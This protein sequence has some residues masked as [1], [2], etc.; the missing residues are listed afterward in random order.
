MER[1]PQRW[2][3]L[4]LAA[5]GLILVSAA[6]IHSFVPGLELLRPGLLLALAGL[7]LLV[8]NY[9]G[10]RRIEHLKNPLGLLLGFLFVWAL[11]TAPFGLYVGNSIRFTLESFGRTILVAVV[12]ATAIRDLHDLER[13][14]K[15]YALG[16]IGFAILGQ[17]T[18]G[19]RDFGGGGYDPNDG[20]MFVVSAIPLV[21]FF[22]LRATTFRER[23]LFGFGLMA[24][25]SGVVLSGSRGGFLAL[26]AVTVFAL[27]FMA[28]VRPVHRIG[29]VLAVLLVVTLQGTG[30]FWE[31]VESTFDADDYNRHSVT[32]RYEIWGRG[33]D[34]V[35][36]NPITGVGIQNFSV[37]EGQHPQIAEMIRR[38][39]GIRY[40]APHSVWVQTAAELG[41]PGFL[42][43]SGAFLLLFRFLWRP[44]RKQPNALGQAARRSLDRSRGL[45]RAFLGGILGIMVA[46]SFLSMAY[47]PLL[48]VPFAI[49]LGAI[50]VYRKYATMLTPGD[51]P[52]VD[53]PGPEMLSPRN[54]A[55]SPLPASGVHHLLHFHRGT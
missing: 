6:R 3:L 38:G 2:D 5:A 16:A 27:I 11:V 47:S 54:P 14:L 23:I 18:S 53:L 17:G 24:C 22:L 21:I 7:G 48:W 40:S 20:A 34:Y 4:L 19:F 42:A 51:T 35:R 33:M 49:G 46:G 9:R 55:A 10:L 36:E 25:I 26:V 37:A 43:F 41:T 1:P 28:G 15:V 13:L 29:A 52:E 12:I 50:K 32:G 8:L 31:R 39:Q 30:E 45:T 44:V